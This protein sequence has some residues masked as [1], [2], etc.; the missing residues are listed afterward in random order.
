MD[1]SLVAGRTVLIVKNPSKG[2]IPANYRTITCLST[3]WKFLSNCLKIVLYR[4]LST[5]GAI[6]FQQKGCT[7]DSKGSKDHLRIDKFIMDDAKRRHRNLFMAWLDVKKAYD[8]VPHDWI[9]H[10]LRKFG[11]HEKIVTFLNSAMCHWS[12]AL[13]VNGMFL[14]K[15][16]IRCG[17][18]QGDSLSPLLFILSLVPLSLILDQSPKGYQ[19]S[20]S[21]TRIN[22]L[23]YM[24]DVKLYGCS[25]QEIESLVHT[26]NIFFD[27]ICMELGA[28]KCNI[29]VISRGRLVQS[30]GIV[31]SSGELIHYLSSAGVYKYLGV[32]EADSIKHQQ[33][34]CMLSK[35]YKRRVRKLLCTKLYSRNLISAIN[36]CAVSLLRYSGGIIKWSQAEIQKLD[37]ATRKLLTMH[38]G[39]CMNSDVDHLYVPRKNGGRGLIS[40]TFAIES[41][42]RNLSHYVHHLEDACTAGM[43]GIV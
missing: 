35:E 21:S 10:C 26:V 17:I 27:D 32:I 6:P 40:V 36:T 29:V 41:E 1:P 14:G 34:K 11:V 12:T 3:I 16:A 37:V 7:L 38:G 31:L 30:D 13:I 23:V 4:H 24:D 2:N 25:Q 8:S 22:H 19:I 20:S 33:M 15:I 42:K 43:V 39:F 9:L 18:F 5:V 28:S